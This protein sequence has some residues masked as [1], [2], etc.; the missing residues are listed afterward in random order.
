MNRILLSLAILLS[1]SM[2]LQT[3]TNIS[4]RDQC[5]DLNHIA[6]LAPLYFDRDTLTQEQ[7]DH[8]LTMFLN[9]VKAFFNFNNNRTQEMSLKSPVVQQLFADLEN[10]LECHNFEGWFNHARETF[11]TNRAEQLKKLLQDNY[12]EIINLLK[13]AFIMPSANKKICGT[14]PHLTKLQKVSKNTRKRTIKM[15][16]FA[17][18]FLGFAIDSYG[19]KT[20]INSPHVKNLFKEIEKTLGCKN[21]EQWIMHIEKTVTLP[22]AH[23][24]I[25]R[26]K[27]LLGEYVSLVGEALIMD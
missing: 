17:K 18:N 4:Q 24:L 1:C 19:E 11:K 14:L 13:D 15:K 22:K 7:K 9:I 10:A 23:Q 25:E 5:G 21:F 20:T 8:Y 12:N 16:A 3:N 26:V 2:E 27:I 6:T